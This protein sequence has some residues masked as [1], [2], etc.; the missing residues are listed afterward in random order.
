[1]INGTTMT[2]GKKLM[3]G[4]GAMAAIAATMGI[5]SLFTI[6]GLGTAFSETAHKSV[7][8]MYLAGAAQTAVSEMLSFERGV[9]VRTAMNDPAK[10]EAYNNSFAQQARSLHELVEEMRPLIAT[11][12]GRRDLDAIANGT[13]AWLPVHDQLWQNCRNKQ[14]EAALHV[15]DQQSMPIGGDMEKAAG[16]MKTLQ[17]SLVEDAVTQAEESVAHNRWICMVLVLTFLVIAAAVV[18]AVRKMTAELKHM[19]AD[20]SGSST[21]IASAATQ[22][23]SAS[24]SLAQGSSEQAA[25]LEETSASA[26]EIASMTRKN[27]THSKS[28]ADAMSKVDEHVKTANRTLDMMVESM[29]EIHTSSDKISK[30]IKVIEEIA[31]QTNILALNAA[32]EAARA[33]EAG[34]G[35]AVVAGEVRSLAQRS[36]QAAKDTAVLIEESIARAKS[37]T[38]K[39]SSVAE[40]IQAIAES[41]SQVKLL[42]D[43]VNV[44]SQQQARGMAQIAKAVVE[45]EQVT[46]KAAASSEQT[47]SASEELSTQA[48]GM[49]ALLEALRRLAG[50]NTSTSKKVC[51]RRANA[52]RLS[53]S[54][55]A[56]PAGLGN[57][58]R[59]LATAVKPAREL[60]PLDDD[61]KEF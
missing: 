14:L 19:A 39:V 11:E 4:F 25:S 36:S 34:M 21:Q 44:G 22:V 18:W 57:R 52:N 13:S 16:D 7:R 42:V 17:K 23:A 60:F 29:R 55:P 6:N 8:K 56:Q 45:I 48:E 61:F 31:F 54:G 46:Q 24:Q 30:I 37:G 33:G 40:A 26:E 20:L 41:A 58:D 28:A 32:V 2:V 35:F 3:I 53:A 12:Q 15:Y 49:C 59:L 47:A 9:L 27:A 38:A 5:A 43:E 1:M 50:V 51:A 10:A